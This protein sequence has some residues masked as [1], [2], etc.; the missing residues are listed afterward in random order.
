MASRAASKPSWR[1][2]FLPPLK[3]R[4]SQNQSTTCG[5]R[6]EPISSQPI[7]RPSRSLRQYSLIEN[8]KYKQTVNAPDFRML[9]VLIE[10]DRRPL[11]QWLLGFWQN[12]LAGRSSHLDFDLLAG[13]QS[14]QNPSYPH[15][16]RK[17]RWDLLFPPRLKLRHSPGLISTSPRRFQPALARLLPPTRHLQQKPVIRPLLL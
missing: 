8:N 14:L 17:A 6:L 15:V 16:N 3:H 4:S 7:S 11:W 10:R 12:G 1:T 5:Q 2:A 13:S 9:I